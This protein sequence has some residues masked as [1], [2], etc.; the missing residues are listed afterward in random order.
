MG[1]I[2]RLWDGSGDL[3][4]CKFEL[5]QWR[6]PVVRKLCGSLRKWLINLEHDCWVPCS[7]TLRPSHDYLIPQ[8]YLT[9]ENTPKYRERG[10]PL[11][12]G[13]VGRGTAPSSVLSVCLN[14]L[15][16]DVLA[17]FSQLFFLYRDS[18]DVY[19]LIPLCQNH[20]A[21]ISPITAVEIS[22]IYGN[23]LRVH[24]VRNC[25]TLLSVVLVE[26]E[27]SLEDSLTEQTYLWRCDVQL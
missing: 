22:D 24:L 10:R 8:M 2:G 9:S 27:G 3:F 25:S 12:F 4:M 18:W 11:E 17:P 1:V 14:Q 26:N 5:P 13:S 16:Q 19:T 21:S 20:T 23:K 15:G 6:R 7:I